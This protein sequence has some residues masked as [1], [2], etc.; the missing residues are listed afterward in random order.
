MAV[1][2][3]AEA[4]A[5]AVDDRLRVVNLFWS[6]LGEAVR[7]L[8]SFVALLLLVRLF[9]PAEFGLL[10]AATGL[11][12]SLFP[13][14]GMGGGWLVLRRVTAE[15]HSTIAALASASG[16]MLLGSAV[17]GLLAAV[18]QP[19]IL[20]QMSLTTFLGVAVSEMLLLGLVET[21]LFAAQAERRLKAKAVTWSLYGTARAA[22]AGALLFFGGASVGLGWWILATI[23]VGLIVL[24]VAQLLT[25]GGPVRPTRPT[26]TDVR[27]GLPYALG[28]GAERVLFVS[29]TVILTALDKA[30]DAGLYAGAR[31]L[32]TVTIAP[33][34]AAL[35]AVSADLWA[36]GGQRKVNAEAVARLAWRFTAFGIA[37]GMAAAGGWILFGDLIAAVLGPQYSES[38]AILPWLSIVPLL[39]VLEV[40]AGTALTASDHHRHRVVVTLTIGAFNI[41]ANLALIPSWGW[42]GAVAA[43]LSASVLHAVALWAVLLWAAR[44]TRLGDDET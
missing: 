6:I 38:A 27:H 43:S 3:G 12:N 31:K 18:A 14:A 30:T 39:L 37:Y 28:F 41:A 34:I 17:I 33:V 9:E 13:F 36:A 1:L 32:M 26:V 42:R 29:D 11:F 16:M 25:V 7:L 23:G 22:A 24:T 5:E 21:T 35:H 44:S 19:V 15:S 20:P 4:S 8:T 10:V 40:F 2:T